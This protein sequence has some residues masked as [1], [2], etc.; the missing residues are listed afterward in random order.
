MGKLGAFPTV[1][2]YEQASQ[3]ALVKEIEQLLVET[4]R[5]LRSPRPAGTLAG[6]QKFRRP[7]GSR[8]G[9]HWHQAAAG[10][11]TDGRPDRHSPAG[12]RWCVPDLQA[13]DVV[14]FDQ[15]ALSDSPHDVVQPAV[16]PGATVARGQ[17]PE[18]VTT[19]NLL[20]DSS[21]FAVVIL[22]VACWPWCRRCCFSADG[23]RPLMS[24][25]EM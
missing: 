25:P 2:H 23:L 3:I 15:S 17:Q 16:G 18:T 20:Q 14:I 24:S 10:S 11:E 19:P 4:G 22:V 13:D 6:C 21:R 5:D 9:H 1:R 8:D 12:R 7:G